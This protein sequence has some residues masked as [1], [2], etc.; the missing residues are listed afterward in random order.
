[1]VV[2]DEHLNARKVFFR[3]KPCLG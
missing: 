3:L 2:L 1:M